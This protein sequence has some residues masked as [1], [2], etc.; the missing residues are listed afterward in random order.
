MHFKF[1]NLLILIVLLITLINKFSYAFTPPP[2]PKPP[3][4]YIVDMANKLSPVNLNNLNARIN[5]VNR[6]SK[7]EIAV[8]IIPSLES[9]N[10]SDVAHTTFNDWKIGKKGLDNGVLIVIAV[11]DRCSRI[12]TGKGVEGDLTDLKTNDILK[13]NLNPFLKK[14]DFYGGLI[15][16]INLLSNTIDSRKDQQTSPLPSSFSPKNNQP[17]NC[18][19]S[20]IGSDTDHGGTIM[21]FLIFISSMIVFICWRK[22]RTS[23]KPLYDADYSSTQSTYTNTENTYYSSSSTVRPV[24]YTPYTREKNEDSLV[25]TISVVAAV[26]PFVPYLTEDND[27]PTSKRIENYHNDN[28]DNNFTSDDHEFCSDDH[29]FGGGESGGGGSDDSWDE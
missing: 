3:R 10:I 11:L 14:G 7:N 23:R 8:L 13:N 5:Q 1:K 17:A 24:T 26:T 20:T 6:I 27:P 25:N 2:A 15:E 4:N 16:T 28:S 29:E 12:E 22:F 19:S 9:E 18:S 21:L